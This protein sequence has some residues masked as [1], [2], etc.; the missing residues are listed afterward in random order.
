MLSNIGATNDGKDRAMH[1]RRPPN[2]RRSWLFLGGADVDG[3]I[4][5]ADSGADVLI[6]E[7]EDFTA[8]DQR[9]VARAMAPTVLA[10]WKERG[11]IAGVRVNPLADCGGEDLTA[12][13][14]GTPDVIMLPKAGEPAH[15]AEIDHAILS[16][17][18]AAE[19]DSG[20]SELVPNI[21]LARG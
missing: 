16:A 4:A 11:I 12:V 1:K 14:P 5:A 7:L 2:F 18:R 21:E 20:S 19:I 13:M 6:H 8:P 17:E 3:L 10:A 15:E 9:P